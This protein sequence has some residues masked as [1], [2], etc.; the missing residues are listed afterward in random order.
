MLSRSLA[1]DSVHAGLTARDTLCQG[2]FL[3]RFWL[4]KTI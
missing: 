3:R 1:A 2:Y 4:T